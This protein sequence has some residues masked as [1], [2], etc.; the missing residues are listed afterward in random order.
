MND[1]KELKE[2]KTG[3]SKSLSV[4]ESVIKHQKNDILITPMALGTSCLFV[5]IKKNFVGNQENKKVKNNLLERL[6]EF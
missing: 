2:N 5:I 1:G 3:F 4:N 6:D